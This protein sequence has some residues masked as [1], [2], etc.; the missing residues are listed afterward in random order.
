MAPCQLAYSQARIR[1]Y[2]LFRQEQPERFNELVQQ[3]RRD[4]G[5]PVA[6]GGRYILPIDHGTENGMRMHY[7]RKIPACQPCR[8]AYNAAVRYRRQQ[9]ADRKRKR[10][11]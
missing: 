5:L 9:A 10:T 6:E 11:A 4:L 8:D 3:A 2:T 7:R 1:A